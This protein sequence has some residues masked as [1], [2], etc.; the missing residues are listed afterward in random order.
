MTTLHGMR[1]YADRDPA[2]VS[3]VALQLTREEARDLV[4]ALDDLL[5]HFDEPGWHAH[6]YSADYQT[7]VSVSADPGEGSSR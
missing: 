6:V 7:E 3:D 2:A 5:E 1:L 4:H